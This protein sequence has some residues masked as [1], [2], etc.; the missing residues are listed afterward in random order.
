MHGAVIR[1]NMV[2]YLINTFNLNM[3][4]LELHI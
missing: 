1:S 4:E 3:T 2:S